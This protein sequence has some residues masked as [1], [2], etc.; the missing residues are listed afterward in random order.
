MKECCDTE[1]EGNIHHK[2]LTKLGKLYEEKEK[3]KEYLKDKKKAII[4]A[5][6]RRITMD[7]EIKE[8]TLENFIKQKI[9]PLDK[10]DKDP[11]KGGCSCCNDCCGNE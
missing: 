6:K 5:I 2:F 10:K 11:I 7:E 1:E 3:L 4:E 9:K 8:E